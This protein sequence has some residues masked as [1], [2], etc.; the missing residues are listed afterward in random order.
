MSLRTTLEKVAANK[1]K[2]SC[3]VETLGESSYGQYLKNLI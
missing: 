1:E 2:Y 3:T